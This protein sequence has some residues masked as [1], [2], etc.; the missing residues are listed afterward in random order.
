M[1]CF[2]RFTRPCSYFKLGNA[3]LYARVAARSRWIFSNVKIGWS[4]FWHRSS[5]AARRIFSLSTSGSCSICERNLRSYKGEIGARGDQD[6][7]K[8]FVKDDPSISQG[9]E[10]SRPLDK[11]QVDPLRVRTLR[12]FFLIKLFNLTFTRSINSAV[13]TRRC[14]HVC[15][16][17]GLTVVSKE[18]SVIVADEIY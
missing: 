4:D 8:D 7:R 16:R 9:L 13:Y 17:R 1:Y 10:V 6:G 2:T 11:F 5:I 3:H 15:A 14:S 18:S 12:R